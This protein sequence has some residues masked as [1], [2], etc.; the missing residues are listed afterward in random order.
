MH[1]LEY[2]AARVRVRH[3]TNGDEGGEPNWLVIWIIIGAIVLAITL[4]V[5]A[6]VI[7]TK[8]KALK[9]IETYF[10][11]EGLQ[12]VQN[13]DPKTRKAFIEIVTAVQMA[14]QQ[15]KDKTYAVDSIIAGFV[16][17]HSAHVK[18][19]ENLGWY[20]FVAHELDALI[21]FAKHDAKAAAESLT[22]AKELRGDGTLI[23]ESAQLIGK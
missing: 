8:K 19:N 23:S 20:R 7:A 5:I 22:K 11:A 13:L 17:P 4:G 14:D 2:L 6:L 3:H 1:Q 21:A 10:G 15:I 12:F 16:K 18:N 9:R